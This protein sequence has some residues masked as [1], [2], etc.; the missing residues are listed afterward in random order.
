MSNDSEKDKYYP[1]VNLA[2]YPGDASSITNDNFRT[3][4]FTTSYFDQ[5]IPYADSGIQYTVQQKEC[6]KVVLQYRMSVQNLD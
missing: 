1:S 5:Y 2:D 4:Y 3:N 6:Y